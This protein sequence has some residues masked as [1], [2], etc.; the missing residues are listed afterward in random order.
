MNALVEL[1]RTNLGTIGEQAAKMSLTILNG[2]T[3][4]QADAIIAQAKSNLAAAITETVVLPPPNVPVNNSPGV[5]ITPTK[6]AAEATS[7]AITKTVDQA[8]EQEPKPKTEA[9]L[10]DIFALYDED[11]DEHRKLHGRIPR[12]IFE[13]SPGHGHLDR[14]TRFCAMGRRTAWRFGSSPA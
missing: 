7:K 4:A 14:F 3:D 1:T 11:N 10:F 12:G 5:D 2:R 6:A 9:G 8:V 13:T